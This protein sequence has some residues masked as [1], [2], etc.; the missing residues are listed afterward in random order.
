[1][2]TL[3]ISGSHRVLW[4]QCTWIMNIH[5][6]RH[7]KTTSN[8]TLDRLRVRGCANTKYLVSIICSWASVTS[9][10]S[11]YS[12]LTSK[13]QTSTFN[14]HAYS[15]LCCNVRVL[16]IGKSITVVS[17]QVLYSPTPN[18]YYIQRHVSR[19]PYNR[20]T[21]KDVRKSWAPISSTT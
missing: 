9:N 21:R 17:S 14:K 5:V 13:A 20:P 11:L 3:L 4:W 19:P 2:G 18:L 1:M 15:K 12:E 7:T 6:I 10:K 16:L 8:T